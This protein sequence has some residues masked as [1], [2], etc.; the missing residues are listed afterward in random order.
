MEH[1]RQRLFFFQH[2]QGICITIITMLRCA[3]VAALTM[4]C[5]G[6]PCQDHLPDEPLQPRCVEPPTLP[7][8]G[9]PR[10]FSCESEQGPVVYP[11]HSKVFPSSCEGFPTMDLLV[12]TGP[13]DWHSLPYLFSSTMLF[14]P[15]Y[16]NFHVVTPDH[17][18]FTTIEHLLPKNMRGLTAH[19]FTPSDEFCAQ[20]LTKRVFGFW[21]DAGQLVN[22]WADNYTAGADYILQVDSDTV[23]NYPVTQ[24][25]VLFASPDRPHLFHWDGVEAPWT[26]ARAKLFGGPAS[27]QF[28]A[29]FP[30]FS[31]PALLRSV[32]NRITSAYKQS[33]D[34]VFSQ[35]LALSQFDMIGRAFVQSLGAEGQASVHPCP[36][37]GALREGMKCGDFPHPMSHVS[38]PDKRILQGHHSSSAPDMQWTLH[39]DFVVRGERYPLV[40]TDII[41]AGW[42]FGQTSEQGVR[43]PWCQEQGLGHDVHPRCYDYQ[44]VRGR[45]HVPAL[46]RGHMGAQWA[47]PLTPLDDRSEVVLSPLL[48]ATRSKW[49]IQTA[50]GDALIYDPRQYTC[51]NA[52]TTWGT[53]GDNGDTIDRNNTFYVKNISLCAQT[54]VYFANTRSA[55]AFMFDSSATLAYG[56]YTA[57]C[58]CREDTRSGDLSG[59]L[60]G[61]YNGV[62]GVRVVRWAA[63]SEPAQGWALYKFKQPL[64]YD[65]Y[66]GYGGGYGGP[67]NLGPGYGYLGYGPTNP[68]LNGVQDAGETGIDC[69]GNCANS[70]VIQD[71]RQ[72]KCSSLIK[73][74]PTW[75]SGPSWEFINVTLADCARTCFSVYQRRVPGFGYQ[76][77]G[78]AHGFAFNTSA[79]P[80]R[81]YCYCSS[82][83]PKLFGFPGC[84]ETGAPPQGAIST[85]YEYKQLQQCDIS[86]ASEMLEGA[87]H[88]F[89]ECPKLQQMVDD[90]MCYEQAC[91][92]TAGPWQ[93][94]RNHGRNTMVCRPL[95]QQF[96]PGPGEDLLDVLKKS[97][98]YYPLPAVSPAPN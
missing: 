46:L 58:Y 57:N 55:N 67:G 25:E 12:F 76:A 72:Y 70:C 19:T 21:K 78:F 44:G 85:I 23:F 16:R 71:H 18:S 95:F 93:E 82:E 50:V 20:N 42:C 30:V 66:I 56:A 1:A 84:P 53:I 54:C 94:E 49:Q 68:C 47:K 73:Y 86:T 61:R 65:G 43:H 97:C 7:G 81:G 59:Y 40:A 79:D 41:M 27:M 37:E 91:G 60:T 6:N 69:G 96:P 48:K 31:T 28:M 45:E 10:L 35:G 77:S 87:V 83:N 11:D 14:M 74:F 9:Y 5:F 63:C 88:A 39:Q 98:Q 75:M 22:L 36:R 2:T 64:G 15:C 24:P 34:W 52:A 80:T 29:K 32:R 17:E 51:I 38:Y 3:M 33:L 4:M 8:T 92:A 62:V 13:Q 26:K 89:D 90:G